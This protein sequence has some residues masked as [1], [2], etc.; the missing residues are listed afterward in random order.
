MLTTLEDTL[1]LVGLPGLMELT[2]GRSEIKVGLIDGPIAFDG[3]EFSGSII[4]EISG[5]IRGACSFIDGHQCNHGTFVA[6]ILASKRGGAAPAICPG[7]TLLIR[8][9]FAEAQQQTPLRPS[10]PPEELAAAIIDLVDAGSHVLNLSIGIVQPLLE[11]HQ[12]LQQALN[13]AAARGV[14]TVAAAGNQG[15]IGSSVLIRHPW[16][17]PVVACDGS[18]RPSGFSNLGSSIGRRGLMAPG[19]E[20]IGIGADGKPGRASGTS[21]ATPFVT[22]AI[23]LLWSLFPG[24]PVGQVRFALTGASVPSR[25]TIVPP[26]MNAWKGYQALARANS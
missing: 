1:S 4:R 5:R 15:A 9:I 7:C 18:G 8:P 19:N 10:A 22:G 11:G 13:Y 21:V 25:T 26:L 12:V 14:L 6:S 3:P 20:V 16:V 23:A 24:A 17:I 2:R